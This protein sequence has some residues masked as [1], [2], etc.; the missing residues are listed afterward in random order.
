MTTVIGVA[1]EDNGH[2]FAVTRIVDDVLVATHRW[3]DGILA[4]CRSWRGM[5]DGEHWYKYNPDD[6][7]DLRP[8]TIDG[9]RIAP[10]GRIR[11]EPLR[12]E[13]GMWRKILML[14]CHSNPRPEVV[15]LVRDVD[16][17]T[18]RW[19]GVKQARDA[20][21]WP[22]SVALA[23]A[24]PE[25]E[26]WLVSGFVPHGPGERKVLEGIRRKLSFDPTTE[27]HRLT[28]HPN[29]APTD[30]KRILAELCGINEER[31]RACLADR[32]TL[33]ERGAA[34]GLALFLD[35]VDQQIVP[36]FGAPR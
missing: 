17:F 35:D 22:F 6:A 29:D 24:E 19:A 23:L 8:I 11:G 2:F 15:V 30:S 31:R 13:A 33:R 3:L 16:G 9:V 5:V 32:A 18:D 12:P 4:D 27:S 28:S 1:C 20:F 7:N 26:A 25:V 34:N 14:F 21:P 10:Q 36:I